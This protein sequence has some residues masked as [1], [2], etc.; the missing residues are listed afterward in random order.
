M[1]ELVAI[2]FSMHGWVVVFGLLGGHP[3][4]LSI[5]IWACRAGIQQSLGCRCTPLGIIREVFLSCVSFFFLFFFFFFT[6]CIGGEIWKREQV[7]FL[8]VGGLKKKVN[9]VER[10][11]GKEESSRR[12]TRRD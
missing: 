1:L 11:K 5:R 10:E 9:V 8:G 12:G 4:E 7:I 3:V 6:K 2:S